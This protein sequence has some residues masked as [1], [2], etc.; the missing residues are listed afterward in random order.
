LKKIFLVF[1]FFTSASFN[2]FAGTKDTTLSGD[3]NRDNI[4]DRV[5]VSFTT[6]E[7]GIYSY[8]DGNFTVNING[9]EYKDRCEQ[10]DV[11]DVKI[12]EIEPNDISPSVLVSCYGYGDQGEYFFYQFKNNK[13]VP[14]GSIKAWGSAEIKGDGKILVSDWMGFWS[15]QA[16][17]FLNKSTNKLELNRQD[18]YEV[19]VEGTVQQSFKLLKSRDDNSEVVQT[20]KPGTKVTLL[21][22]DTKPVCAK[23]ADGYEDEY[24]C[25]WYLMKTAGGTEGWVRMKDF[26]ENI[27][28]LPWAG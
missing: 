4:L 18:T 26:R 27:N 24:D 28:D 6:N 20:L 9:A 21:K 15:L 8:L 17:Y 5:K 2:I 22:C 1:L 25:D 12:V 14:L 10:A 13:V 23:N 3:L 11:F 16:E 19:N 7:D